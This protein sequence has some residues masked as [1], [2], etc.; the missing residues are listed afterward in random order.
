[1]LIIVAFARNTI[2][3]SHNSKNETLAHALQPLLVLGTLAAVWCFA[4]DGYLEHNF[5]PLMYTIGFLWSRNIIIM[6][7]NYITKSR[8]N[9]WNWPFLLYV[10]CHLA[11]CLHSV[12]TRSSYTAAELHKFALLMALMQVGFWLE[13]VVSV[14]LQLKKILGIEVFSIKAQLGGVKPEGS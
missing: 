14:I 6:Q 13:F 2:T 1:M 12:V 8:L 4:P 3:L 7:L 5:Y 10:C 11:L 9:I